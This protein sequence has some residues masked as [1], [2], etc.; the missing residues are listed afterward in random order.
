M[1]KNRASRLQR[2]GA[3]SQPS[4]NSKSKS[5]PAS[6]T[7]P[8]P[9]P[10]ETAMSNR[11]IARLITPLGIAVAMVGSAAAQDTVKIGMVMP[12][13]G[14]LA[15]AGKQVAAGARLYMSEHGNKVA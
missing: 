1:S 12:L 13:T 9:S 3:S 14:T 10:A 4:L 5:E 8:Q 6:R 2:T 15:S 11:Y 7:E